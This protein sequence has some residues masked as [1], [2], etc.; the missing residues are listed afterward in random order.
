M[1]GFLFYSTGYTTYVS[2]VLQEIFI[3]DTTFL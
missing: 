3:V 2:S 1:Q